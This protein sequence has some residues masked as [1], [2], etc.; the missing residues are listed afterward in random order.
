MGKQGKLNELD[1]VVP[2]RLSQVEHV[3]N[4][5]VPADLSQCLVFGNASLA[6]LQRRIKELQAE[7]SEQRK[8][9]KEA[10]QQHVHLIKSRKTME[11]RTQG[12]PLKDRDES[13]N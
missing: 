11:E 8:F 5:Q 1:V 4:A 6:A 2:L 13:M 10:R 7:K 3:I 12:R 9:Y